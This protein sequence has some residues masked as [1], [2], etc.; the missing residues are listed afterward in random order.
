M[1]LRCILIPIGSGQ[2]LL[3]SA[4]IAE[5]C[6]YDEPKE[7][8]NNNGVLG[9]ID[10]R[11]KELP[12][13]SVEDALSLPTPYCVKK[14]HKLILYGLDTI[15]FYAIRATDMPRSLI[16]QSENLIELEKIESH[17]GLIYKV[18]YE[19]EEAWLPDLS[20]LEG[21]VSQINK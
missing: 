2:L 6:H 21:I 1:I 4:V 14:Y 8:I 10:W 16:V 9:F 15:E 11:D 18:Q 5:I 19:S 3:P 7:L 20:Y 17:N 13:L 12:L